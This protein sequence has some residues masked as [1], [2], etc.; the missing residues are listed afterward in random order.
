MP[1]CKNKCLIHTKLTQMHFGFQPPEVVPKNY[2]VFTKLLRVETF[3]GV[4]YTNI[5]FV[6]LLH[7]LNML[8]LYVL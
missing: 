7:S 4:F 5:F 3:F 8:K 6:L 2:F 1:L